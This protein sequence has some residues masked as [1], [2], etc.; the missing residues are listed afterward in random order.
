MSL[1]F[2]RENKSGRLDEQ[3]EPTLEEGT[4]VRLDL[5]LSLAPDF[6]PHGGIR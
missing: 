2:G 3:H 6:E 5:I 4:L 1:C